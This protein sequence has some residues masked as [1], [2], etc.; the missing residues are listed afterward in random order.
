MTVAMHPF[1][2]LAASE[3][4]SGNTADDGLYLPIIART[5]GMLGQTGV[6][7]AG[8]AKM[9]AL[10]TRGQIAFD[11][12]YFLTVAPQTGDMV[13]LLPGLI[14]AALGGERQTLSLHNEA[15]QVIGCGYEF[16]RERTVVLPLGPQG[17][18][19]E[20]SFTE[21]VQV[22]RSDAHQASASAA[23]DERLPK[24]EAALRALTPAPGRGRRQHQTAESLQAA[25][26]RTLAA[27]RVEQLLDVQWQSEEQ[28]TTRFVGRGRGSANRATREIVNTRACVTA[29]SR[30]EAAIAAAKERLGWRVQLTNAPQHISLESCVGQYRGNWRGERNYGRLKSEPLGLSPLFVRKPDQIIGKTNLL[31]LAARVESILEFEIA[32]GLAAEEKKMTGLHP[33]LPKQQTPTPTTPA[34]LSA[35]VRCQITLTVIQWHSETATYLTPLPTLLV[36]VLRYLHLPLTLYTDLQ[37][38]SD[39]DISI[40]GK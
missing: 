14:Q 7:Y 19:Q 34:L 27:H 20:F 31:T 40:F 32:R 30:D 18:P 10:A 9:A 35:I 17:T 5:R 11:G 13:K 2:H 8:D 26:A 3:V 4:V 36:D 15:G 22:I 12:D 21:R 37:K 25:I 33:G 6:L 16:E 28:R 1:G 29:V 38:I 39:F 23:L 24:A